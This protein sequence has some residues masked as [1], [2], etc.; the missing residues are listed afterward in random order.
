MTNAKPIL[1]LTIGDPAGIGPEISL[2]AAM[3]PAVRAACRLVL[4]GDECV[5]RAIAPVAKFSRGIVKLSTDR[6][7][8][9]NDVELIDTGSLTTPPGLGVAS[10]EGGAAS[11]AAIERAIA[12][13]QRGVVHGVVT[14]PINKLALSM[15]G[16]KFPGHTEIFGE[17]TKSKNYAMMMYGEKLAVGLVTCH[18]S[19][20]SVPGDLTT[21]RIV[22]VGKLL[23]ESVARIRGAAP[24]VAVLGLNPHAGEAGLF[25]RE[26]IEIVAPAVAE[27]RALGIDA[28]GPLPPDTAFTP[29]A[30]ARYGAHVCLYHDQGLIPFK[31]INFED[32]VNVTMGLPFP[33]T[34]VDHGTAYD[35][36]GSGRA[37]ITSMIQ[38]ILLAAKLA[39]HA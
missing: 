11:F 25:G 36:A 21:E 1:A 19:L 33:R 35:L 34:S 14:A 5:L 8:A 10:R 9:E 37:E 38:A 2:R 7:A 17:Y 22:A 20:A 13:A 18:Q 3:E 30:L 28:E 6:A 32:G 12:E 31:M 23:S 24:R 4:V 15:A 26:E 27:L 16:V 29:R 39:G